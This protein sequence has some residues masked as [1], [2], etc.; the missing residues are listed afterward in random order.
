[1]KTIVI[2]SIILLVARITF[3]GSLTDAANYGQG[4]KAAPSEPVRSFTTEDLE[5]RYGGGSSESA[6]VT[7]SSG[8]SPVAYL[9]ANK[10][11]IVKRWIETRKFAQFGVAYNNPIHCD[12]AREQRAGG[13][14]KRKGNSI[15]D[16][17]AMM[18]EIMAKKGI[19]KGES[20]YYDGMHE[21]TYTDPDPSLFKADVV[22]SFDVTP[23]DAKGLDSQTER[24]SM[25]IY[26]HSPN[27]I[28]LQLM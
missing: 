21:G 4:E 19:K 13:A 12:E 16:G 1:M 11:A 15:E 26:Y 5:K 22:C 14:I 18:D 2:V 3:A 28:R 17:Q 8:G 9:N 24:R 20:F 10:V 25:T 23:K 6:N 7:D 27:D